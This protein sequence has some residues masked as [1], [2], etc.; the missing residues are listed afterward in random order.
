MKKVLPIVLSAI[1]ISCGTSK[2]VQ[3]DLTD[4]QLVKIDTIQRFPNNNEKILTWQ[5]DNHMSYVTFVP[6]E[7]YYKVGARMK[8]MMRR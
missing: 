3:M 4:V 1:V 6:M 7:V 8:V 5:D 2:E